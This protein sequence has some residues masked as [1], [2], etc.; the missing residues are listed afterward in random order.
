M[1][2]RNAFRIV[3]ANVSTMYK[4][5]LYRFVCTAIFALIAYFVVLTDLDPLF[6]ASETVALRDAIS[7]LIRTF[8]MGRGDES[9][10]IKP[11]FDAFLQML[12]RERESL[13]S[14]GLETGGLLLLLR[15]FY[16]FG[17]Y[18]F[19]TMIDGFMSSMN[20]PGFLTASLSEP[21]KA[22]LYALIHT[23]ITFVADGVILFVG[24][25]VVVY[26]FS[27]FSVFSLI[28]SVALT[29]FLFALKY[30]MLTLF[31][32]NLVCDKQKV[33]EAL[34]HSAPSARN[35]RMLI[36]GYA[37]L[38]LLFFYINASFGLF[39]LYI[40]LILSLPFTSL[41]FITITLI[42]KYIVSERSY[43]TD[44]DTVVA[45]KEKRENA[46]MLKYL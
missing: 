2:I 29:V 21:G 36:G 1:R 30:T 18:A 42:D 24:V 6:K 4:I 11:A 37:F 28:L 7:S 17:D 43:Y 20:K 10:S 26:T 22:A 34:G 25:V 12:A 33:G 5:V 31:L 15:F 32:P 35:F 45:P 19:A 40:G 44:Y 27:L 3:L 38:I 16:S 8:L 41:Y 39:T 13:V 23:I 9:E 46:D 14:V